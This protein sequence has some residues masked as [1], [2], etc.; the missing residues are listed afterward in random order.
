[1]LGQYLERVRPLYGRDEHPA[2]FLTERG[3]RLQREY[4]TK[5]F[6]EYRDHLELPRELSPHCLRHSHITHLIEDGWDGTFI[7]SQ[8]GHKHGSTT[9]LY[10]GVSSDFKNQVL[11]SNLRKQLAVTRPDAG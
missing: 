5:R 9:A 8:A 6:A 2:L 7:Q 11:L 10:T 4:I 3:G 1:M